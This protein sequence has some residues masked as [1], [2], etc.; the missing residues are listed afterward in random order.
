[1]RKH[2]AYHYRVPAGL[3]ALWDGKRWFRLGA[4]L[5]GAY[6]VWAERLG[7]LEA[8]RTIGQLLDRYAIEVI[9][10]KAPKTQ[11]GNNRAL[12]TLRAVFG[13]LP[14][15]PFKP[16]LI[17]QYVDRRGAKIAAHREI[18][19]LSHAFTKA[20]EWGYIDRHPFKGEVRLEGETPRTRY[21]EDW[22][23]V[24]ALALKPR[25]KAGSV[26]AVQAYIRMKLLTGMRRGDLLRLRPAR[27]CGEDGIHVQ[28][29]KTARSTGKRLVIEWSAELRAAVEMALATRPVD[30]APYL[31]CTRRGECYAKEDGSANG[32]DSMWGR[33]MDRL[34]AETKIEERFTEHDLRAKCA[35]DAGS[36][37]HARALLA[38]ADA[39]TTD[40]VYRRRPER[41]KPLR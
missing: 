9:P 8:A 24:E 19:V 17:Y 22:E 18:E 31:F 6:K 3:E 13:H 41:V 21:V 16:R 11:A 10:T 12:P 38:H 23:V 40:R 37:E 36:L 27:D 15:T 7:E 25:R 14:L 5:P 1:M 33:F 4:T 29:R 35:S 32:W 39:R 34:L 20:V 28:P 30:I 2:G 26:L